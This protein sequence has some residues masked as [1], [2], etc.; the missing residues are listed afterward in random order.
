MIAASDV[1]W[2]VF[3]GT[4]SSS[5]RAGTRITPP[6]TPNSPASTPASTPT[7]IALPTRTGVAAGAGI[8]AR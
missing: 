3:C 6:P 4:A 8:T 7:A 1:A 2:A 5:T